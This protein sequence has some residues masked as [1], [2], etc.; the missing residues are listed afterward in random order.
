MASPDTIEALATHPDWVAPRSDKRVFLGQ[1][2]APEATKTTVEPGN[3]FS[4]GM[5]TFGVTW[6]LR[7]PDRGEF[8]AT[9]EAP[10][11]SL[12]WRFEDGFLPVVVCEATVDGLAVRHSLFQD[13]DASARSEAICGEIELTAAAPTRVELFVSLRSLGPT[14]GLVSELAAGDDGASLLLPSRGLVVLAADRRADAAGC[15]VGDPSPLARVGEVPPTLQVADPDGWCYGVL[16][17]DVSLAA[18]EAWRLRFDCPQQTYGNLEDELPGSAI[19]APEAFEVRRDAH[20]VTWRD[21]LER[22]ALDVPDRAFRDA[23]FAGLQHMLVATVGDQPRIAPLAYPLPW[24]RDSVFIVRCLDLAGLHDDARRLTEYCARNDFFGGFGAEGDSPGQGIWAIVQ[25]FRLTGD[26]AW[27]AR[28]TRRSAA[29]RSGCSGCAGPT[30]RS[31]SSSTRRRSPYTH[32]ERTSGVICVAAADGVI[33]GSMDHGIEYSIGW[34]NQW[35]VLGLREAAFAAGDAGRDRR[36][37]RLLPRGGRTVRRGRAV[38]RAP[39]LLL[40]TRSHHEQP[41]LADPRLGARP[42]RHRATFRR[43]VAGAAGD[44]GRLPPRAAVALFRVRPGA[45]RVAARSGAPGVGRPRLPV[46]PPGRARFVRLARG[47]QRRGDR[48]AI[49]GVTLFHQ[50]RGCQRFDDIAPHGWSQAE[51]WL[52]QRAV[53]SRSGRAGCS[54]SR[55]CRPPGSPRGA[56]SRSATSRPGTA[57]CRRNFA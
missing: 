46:A 51:M 30:A 22:V 13:G 5:L 37:R 27:L 2:G 10:L 11:D 25:H 7:F 28:C 38:C 43:V 56:G 42:R 14:G 53:W 23:F 17:Y 33:R 45:Q 32:A 39:P 1:P 41:A 18:G 16:R 49:R 6:W 20:L 44:D 50:L 54:C 21:R 31:R 47:R 26:R 12:R 36:R 8:F 34:I 9:E 35:A 15:G 4:P 3:A 48:N 40:L 24:L 29:R 55:A 19:A 52:L 57:A